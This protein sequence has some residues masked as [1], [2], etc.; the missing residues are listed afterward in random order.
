MICDR[1]YVRRCIKCPFD[2][3]LPLPAIKKRIIYLDQFV[4]SNMM[5]ELEA[6]ATTDRP[7]FYKALFEKLDHLSKLQLIVCPESPIQDHESAVDP[8]YEKF[9]AVFRL[10]SH[11][12]SFQ[13]P[14]TILHAQIARAFRCWLKG[15]PCQADVDRRFA[16]TKNPDVWQDRYRIDVNYTMDGFVDALKQ[17][18]ELV[19]RYL[20]E[21]CERWANEQNFDFKQ[22]FGD[23]LAGVG[24]GILGE[25]KRY[26]ERF[27]AAARGEAAIDDNVVFAPPASSLV[28]RMLGDA[29]STYPD[30]RERIIAIRIF[31]ASEYLHGVSG[32]RIEALFWA[33]IARQIRHGRK[34]F[35]RSGMY[36][37][38]DAVA[39]YSAFCDAMFL[40]NEVAHLM[41][42]RELRDEFRECR[43]SFFSLRKAD[44][45]LAYLDEIKASISTEH[46]QLVDEVYGPDWTTPYIDLLRD[47]EVSQSQRNLAAQRKLDTA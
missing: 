29:E 28:S 32:A 34:K 45:F 41:T 13:A 6:P 12:I 8:R 10:F 40:D 18:S 11:G 42:D 43:A 35:P 15:E 37:D 31:F 39:M 23:E 38:I 2:Q 24:L 47:H 36:N 30:M 7:A 17:R 33:T 22:T 25:H 21:K 46:L 5:K 4:I 44:E 1:H 9:R 26:L 16:L 20:D 14:V 19:T 27:E 3:S